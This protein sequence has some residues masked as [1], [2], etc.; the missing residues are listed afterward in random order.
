M[1]G[2]ENFGRCVSASSCDAF[3]E[4]KKLGRFFKL[5]I[6]NFCKLVPTITPINKRRKNVFG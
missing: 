1:L 3:W 4:V 5:G 6:L 2:M